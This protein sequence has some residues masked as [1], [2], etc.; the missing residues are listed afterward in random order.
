MAYGEKLIFYEAAQFNRHIF[1]QQEEWDHAFSLTARQ[2]LAYETLELTAT[3]YY[4]L[5]SEEWMVRPAIVWNAAESLSLSL[6]A[7][8]MKGNDGTVF[9][10]ASKLM[11]GVFLE[12]KTSF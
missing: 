1:H 7:Q 4:N 5:T 6:G 3:G 2:Q 12:L 10:H 9:S 8:W 11:N